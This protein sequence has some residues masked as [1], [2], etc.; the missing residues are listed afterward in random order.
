MVWLVAAVIAL[1]VGG[2]ITVV[3]TRDDD[4]FGGNRVAG[5]ACD[6]L[7]PRMT[8]EGTIARTG[9]AFVLTLDKPLCGA[10]SELVSDVS[11][12][13]AGGEVAALVGRRA[14]VEGR[15]TTRDASP[16]YVVQVERVAAAR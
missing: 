1:T 9:D 15:V 10:S 7:Q 4:L 6:A 11:L 3:A 8:L 14:R 5:G 16:A 13:P 12:E 2:A